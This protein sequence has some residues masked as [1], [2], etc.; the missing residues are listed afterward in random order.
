MAHP[1]LHGEHAEQPGPPQGERRFTAGLRG[2]GAQRWN[3]GGNQFLAS[4]SRSRVFPIPWAPSSSRRPALAR[5]QLRRGRA[6]PGQFGLP[7]AEGSAVAAGAL[8]RSAINQ[9]SVSGSRLPL[10]RAAPRSRV[11]EA[12]AGDPV[13]GLA[14]R[15]RARLG[16]RLHALGDVHGVTQDVVGGPPPAAIGAATTLP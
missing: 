9:K 11:L 7:T 14:H 8:A 5:P 13:E 2:G 15:D 4:S 6:E 1:R 3:P 16:R 10:R 12:R